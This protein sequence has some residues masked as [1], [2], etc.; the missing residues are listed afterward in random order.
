MVPK[1]R[2]WFYKPCELEVAAE[3]IRRFLNLNEPTLDAE[4]E[5]EWAEWGQ[6]QGE[7]DW[8]DLARLHDDGESLF[9]EPFILMARGAPALFAESNTQ[10]LANT[11][12]T[13][14]FF[15]EI[16]PLSNRGGLQQ[17]QTKIERHFIPKQPPLA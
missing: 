10:M 7:D 14:V 17:Y 2:F 3:L 5:W 6:D 8:A 13:E 4:N 11:L 16:W 1:T 12:E 15:G 9:G